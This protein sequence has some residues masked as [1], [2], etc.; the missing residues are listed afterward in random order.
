MRKNQ[1][2]TFTKYNEND[3]YYTPPVLVELILPY[4]KKNSIIWCPFDTPSSEFVKIFEKNGHVVIYS[5]IWFGYDFFT[6]KPP[7]F[8]YIISNPPFTMKN[9]VLE[10]LISFNKPFAMVLNFQCLSQVGTNQIISSNKLEL[11]IPNRCISYNGKHTPFLSVYVCRK[12]ISKGLI[13]SEV[14]HDNHRKRFEG[15]E[16]YKKSI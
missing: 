8:D 1:P 7:K 15:S 6:Y 4:I 13:Y 16:M 9:K 2:Q 5:H 12:M 14:R 10:R 3:E 11:L